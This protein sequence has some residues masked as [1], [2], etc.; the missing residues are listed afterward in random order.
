[1]GTAA[2]QAVELTVGIDRR[3]EREV[4]ACKET[5][6]TLEQQE[7]EL[8][9]TLEAA[10]KMIDETAEELG[11]VAQ[12]QDRCM[13]QKRQLEEKLRGFEVADNEE[14]RKIIT[15]LIEGLAAKIVA[16]DDQVAG[17]MQ[18]DDQLRLLV[19]E[20][21]KAIKEGQIK[22][23]ELKEQITV[24]D[25]ALKVDPGIPVV[26]V[27]GTI[28][29]KTLVAGPLKKISLQEAMHCVRISETQM[30]GGGNRW[31]IKISNLR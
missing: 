15:G 24:L 9:I 29:A 5:L 22:S 8:K 2:S 18:K 1:V 7:K 26:K 17:L 20:K 31:Q 3:H 21:E 23:Q 14:E 6:A 13:V 25:E 4:R 11:D 28:H 12:A 10:R 30:E 27:S 16:I 19:V